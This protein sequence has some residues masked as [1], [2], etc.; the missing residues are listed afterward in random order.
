M[1][2]EHRVGAKKSKGFLPQKYYV[3]KYLTDNCDFFLYAEKVS[4]QP[5]GTG[6]LYFFYLRSQL[7]IITK[8]VIPILWLKQCRVH[9]NPNYTSVE[10]NLKYFEFCFYRCIIFYLN[11]SYIT[12]N[13]KEIEEPT[14]LLLSQKA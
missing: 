4:K 6:L 8:E 3:A 13:E 5:V 12:N 9:L 10:C 2:I 11:T 14:G 1:Q 7:L